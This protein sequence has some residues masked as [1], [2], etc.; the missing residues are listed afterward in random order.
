MMIA[1]MIIGD[2]MVIYNTRK[3]TKVRNGFWRIRF[4]KKH[5]A[6][7]KVKSYNFEKNMIET[8]KTEYLYWRKAKEWNDFHDKSKLSV[9]KFIKTMICDYVKKTKTNYDMDIIFCQNRIY[10]NRIRYYLL[11]NIMINGIRE[12]R[13]VALFEAHLCCED[14]DWGFRDFCS[15]WKI[16]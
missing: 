15:V 9:V 6:L 10:P 13:R 2:N 14:D 5:K 7:R 12:R 8:R 16:G 1:V 11:N 4:Y 3:I